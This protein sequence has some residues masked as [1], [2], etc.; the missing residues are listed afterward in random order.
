MYYVIIW[1]VHYCKETIEL[2]IVQL[3]ISKSLDII[4]SFF[5]SETV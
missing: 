2:G 1:I 3:D 5:L 4:Q